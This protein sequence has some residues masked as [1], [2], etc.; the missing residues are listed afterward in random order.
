LNFIQKNYNTDQMVLASVG[1]IPNHKVQQYFEKYF[2]DIPENRRVLHRQ[3]FCNYVPFTTEKRKNTFQLHAVL[4]NIGYNLKD[5]KRV[6]LHLLSNII[7]GPGMI[8]RLNLAL[9]ERRGLSYNIE[10][11][12]TP[13][14]DTGLFTLYFSTDKNDL[15]KCLDIIEKEFR[16]LRSTLMGTIQLK[17]AK[18]QMTGQ[19]AISYESYESQMLSV[20]KS[21]LVYDKVD[22]IEEMF[23]KIEA[24]TARELMDIANE[25]LNMDTLSTLI[26]K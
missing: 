3:P 15:A 23:K 25:V 7:G 5:P 2:K 22:S 18:Q 24:I 19:M 10:A 13:Y 4:G 1:N 26:Y 9:R 8:S 11:S 17:K 12:Y 21:Y 6:G 14:S 20:G 16:T